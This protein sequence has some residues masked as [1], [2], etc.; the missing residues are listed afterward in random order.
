MQVHYVLSLLPCAHQDDISLHAK[1][2]QHGAKP[3]KTVI[4]L[5]TTMRILYPKYHSHFSHEVIDF[6][7]QFRQ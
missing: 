1:H 3:Q 4:F 5:L 6:F 2:G 7:L